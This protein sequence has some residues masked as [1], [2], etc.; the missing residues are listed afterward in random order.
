MKRKGS[1]VKFAGSLTT[2]AICARFESRELLS[3]RVPPNPIGGLFSLINNASRAD[4]QLSTDTWCC[5][6]ATKLLFTITIWQCISCMLFVGSYK[7]IVFS[8]QNKVRQN[9]HQKNI[10]AYVDKSDFGRES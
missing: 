8:I 3:S 9:L 1:R 4:K 2:R 6:G 10:I 7:I 5:H